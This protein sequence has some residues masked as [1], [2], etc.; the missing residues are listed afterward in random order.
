VKTAN[1]RSLRER[2]SGGLVI[3]NPADFSASP[4]RKTLLVSKKS[5]FLMVKVRNL[6]GRIVWTFPKGHL[7]PGE[8]DR[9]AALREVLE[10]T[11]WKCGILNPQGKKKCFQKV[12]YRFKRGNSPVRKTVTWFLMDP[13][14]KTGRKDPEEILEIRWFSIENAGR[15]ALYPSDKK[16]L[17]KIRKFA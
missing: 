14:A 4:S 13:I 8:T 5:R 10:E 6:E 16:L 2:S 11:G 12:R 15:R 3:K 1:N 7:E 17:E 9:D